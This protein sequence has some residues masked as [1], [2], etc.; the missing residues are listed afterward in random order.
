VAD[1]ITWYFVS[2][3]SGKIDTDDEGT[4]L[5]YPTQTGAVDS[6]KIG[7]HGDIGTRYVVKAEL[8]TVAVATRSWTLVSAEPPADPFAG[9]RPYVPGD[10]QTD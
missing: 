9:D 2:T 10:F 6:I 5:H 3:V 7:E 4:P 8:K 1:K